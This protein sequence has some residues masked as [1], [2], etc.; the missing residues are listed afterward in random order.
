RIAY[1][2]TEESG[3]VQWLDP[4]QTVGTMNLLQSARM[5][6]AARRL[7]LVCIAPIPRSDV[8]CAG[9][10]HPYV[11]TQGEAILAR[12]YVPCQD[13]PSV[14]MPYTIRIVAPK[15]L[16]AVAAGTHVKDTPRA[17]Y[18]AQ[19]TL[20]IACVSPLSLLSLCSILLLILSPVAVA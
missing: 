9:K 16:V 3:G 2:T 6:A 14:K 8:C 5:V 4:S 7:K 18:L 11:Y 10:K 1:A 19:S 17:L 13:T 12:T 15:P 20:L